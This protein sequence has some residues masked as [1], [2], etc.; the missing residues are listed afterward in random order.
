MK[1][2]A[3][4]L[5]RIAVGVPIIAVTIAG[6]VLLLLSATLR[7]RSV[8]L[9]FLLLGI[10][11]LCS[12]GYQRREWFRKI[13]RR[14]YSMLVP[15][16]MLAYLAPMMLAPDGAPSVGQVENRYLRGQRRFA[17]FTPANVIPER[18]Q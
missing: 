8:G 11:L 16:A 10:A 3:A 7:G 9:S 15:L 12:I 4:S 1:R 14:F 6:A 18:D 17:R 2:I 5:L 13:R